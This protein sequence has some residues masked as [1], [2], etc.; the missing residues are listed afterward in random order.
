MLIDMLKALILILL[1][2]KTDSDLASRVK[3]A[4][5]SMNM[6]W[7]KIPNIMQD[8]NI[9]STAFSISFPYIFVVRY[10]IRNLKTTFYISDFSLPKPLSQTP[11]FLKEPCRS[12][13]VFWL[14]PLPPL[15]PRWVKKKWRPKKYLNTGHL[16]MAWGHWDSAQLKLEMG[17]FWEMTTA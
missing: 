10:G 3:T 5:G 16:D 15:S 4:K 11:W 8:E 7:G 17:L 9:F 2:P 12:R 14:F 13:V 6:K 1:L